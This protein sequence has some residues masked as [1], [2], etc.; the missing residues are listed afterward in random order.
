MSPKTNVPLMLILLITISGSSCSYESGETVSKGKLVKGKKE[1]LWKIYDTKGIL[2]EH[3]NYK[4]D[5]LNGLRITFDKRGKIYT[6]AHYKMGIF[7]DSFFLYYP[8]GQLRTE[9]WFDSLGQE[10]GIFKMYHENGRLSAIGHSVNGKTEDTVRAYTEN[11]NLEYIE[12]YTNQEKE[13][14]ITYFS[15]KGIPLKLEHYKNDS[16]IKET[17]LNSH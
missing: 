2:L 8:N 16:L 9:S 4:D 5:T 10:Q 11:G 6:K 14:T 1:G 12:Y 15:A 17:W 7:V 3:N 13:R